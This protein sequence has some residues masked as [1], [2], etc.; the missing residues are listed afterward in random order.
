MN[1]KFMLC[2]TCEWYT[3]RYALN[4]RDYYIIVISTALVTNIGHLTLNWYVKQV[5]GL[6][7]RIAFV[8]ALSQKCQNLKVWSIAVHIMP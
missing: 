6:Q 5:A 7:S 8:R 3:S 4:L 1:R 2:L